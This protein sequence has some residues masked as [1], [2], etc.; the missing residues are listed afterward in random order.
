VLGAQTNATVTI[1]DDD[2]I[3]LFAGD[4]GATK[5]PSGTTTMSFPITLSQTS[6]Y[7]V[8][9]Y[10]ATANITAEADVDYL[11]TT[12]RL[13][14]IPGQTS[15]T[16]AVTILTDGLQE[17]SKSFLLTLSNPTN[18]VFGD[19]SALGTIYDGTQGVLQFSS[20]TYSAGE[21]AGSATITVTRTGG[22][23]G[24]VSVPFSTSG[25]SAT[26]GNDFVVTN[27]VLSF[28]NGITS[29][30]FTVNIVNDLMDEDNETIALQLG[31]PTGTTLGS[32]ASATLTIQDDDL[33]PVLSIQSLAADVVLSWPTQASN[34][35]LER[36]LAIGNTNWIAVTNSPVILADKFVVTNSV[37][38]S[39]NFYRL[40]RQ[41]DF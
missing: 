2:P 41:G 21:S 30:S 19:S 35:Q 34:F 5:P 14:F 3:Y 4:A 16:V 10:Y 1:V 6:A 9:V 15:Q 13:D 7:T 28:A 29:R 20:A 39:N 11:G 31:N 25:I 32:P 36:A 27:G 23:L 18:A 17:G 8:S 22:S 37:A 26:S 33:P 38:A 24:T 12:G 40:R